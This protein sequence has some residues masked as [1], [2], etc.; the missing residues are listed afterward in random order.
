MCFAIVPRARGGDRVAR[1]LRGSVAVPVATP[2]HPTWGGSG[3]VRRGGGFSELTP[4]PA[5]N[6]RWWMRAG[7]RPPAPGRVARASRPGSAGMRSVVFFQ[8]PAKSP[9][10]EHHTT[11]SANANTDHQSVACAAKAY[12]GGLRLPRARVAYCPVDAARSGG[13]AARCVST[14]FRGKQREDS[15]SDDRCRPSVAHRRSPGPGRHH[16]TGDGREAAAVWKPDD[17]QG[18][19]ETDRSRSGAN[20]SDPE[21]TS[22]RY[23]N[24]REC[25]DL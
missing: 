20:R 9:D 17:K 18:R 2:Q 8:R 11:S 4:L 5:P 19:L 23:I 22:Y 12:V 25:C 24:S 10:N 7:G 6:G 14:S 1:D 21:G 15:R 13:L 16:A 3:H